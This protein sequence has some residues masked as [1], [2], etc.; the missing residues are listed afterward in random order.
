MNAN[1]PDGTMTLTAPVYVEA[2]KFRPAPLYHVILHNDETHTYEYVILM[3]VQLFRKTVEQAYQHAVEVDTAGVTIVDT[4][5]LE[6]AELKRD[7]I[8]AFGP[9]KMLKNSRGSMSASI[10]PAP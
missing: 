2:T 10:E 7:Q 6:R 8:L 4:T 9:D 1:H 3:L 5:N